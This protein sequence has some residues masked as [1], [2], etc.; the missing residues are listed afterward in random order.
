[1]IK[2]GKVVI[3][4]GA[5]FIGSHLTK[6]LIESGCDVTVF[7]VLQLD[8]GKIDNLK[9]VARD[10]VFIKGDVRDF[11]VLSKTMKG[12]K[13]VFHLSAISHLPV[14][15]DNPLTGIEVNCGGTLNVLEASRLNSVET[16][17]F[18]GSDHIYGEARYIPIDEK[19]LYAPKDAYS[20]S[21][22]Q[23]IEL[24]NLY[25]SCYGLDTRI[26][27]SGNT[28]GEYQDI[29]KATPLFIRQALQNLPIIVNGGNQ[30]RGFYYIN[31]L[32]DAY[33]IVA[34]AKRE[35][36]P[37][38]NVDGSEEIS[39]IDYARKI[40]TMSGSKS[41]LSVLPYRYDEHESL[42]LFLDNSRIKSLG[43]KESVG[44]E[45]GLKKTIE[46]CRGEI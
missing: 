41:T 20:L 35:D 29:S 34:N 30:T 33:L 8:Y 45:E 18:A 12:V 11:N 16:V 22:V 42:R 1:M 5:G 32:V 3:T 23:A 43:Y 46:W 26:I 14:C 44:L 13:T 15:K 31:N 21:K 40:I 7:D 9:H 38:Y 37:I 17:I 10:I 2:G 39:I 36:E 27:I 25:R 19:H 28:F 4:G 6:K 24:C